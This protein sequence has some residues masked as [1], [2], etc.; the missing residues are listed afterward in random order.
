LESLGPSV[1][2]INLDLH[3]KNTPRTLNDLQSKQEYSG[4]VEDEMKSIHT[5]YSTQSI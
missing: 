5:P 2:K 4:V 3:R 1:S